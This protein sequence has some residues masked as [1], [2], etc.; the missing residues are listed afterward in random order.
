M[1]GWLLARRG[2]RH[3]WRTHLG[4]LLGV[5]CATTVLVGALSVGDSVRHSLLEQ[6]LWR[7]GQVSSVLATGDRFVQEDLGTRIATAIGTTNDSSI[8]PRCV[9]AIQLAGVAASASGKTRT[10]I[11]D[12]FG[13]DNRFFAMSAGGKQ[14]PAL[15]AGEAILNER[16]AAQLGVTVD[17]EIVVRVEKPSLMP[18]EAAMAT[19]D[20]VSF[21]L[22]VKI[23]DIVDEQEF[24]HFG[25]RASQVPPFNLF[26]SL[27]W[28][29]QELSLPGR[30]NMLLTDASVEAADAALRTKWTIADAE[31]KLT[32]RDLGRTVEL[33][34]TRVFLDSAVVDAVAEIAPESVGVVTY[35]VKSLSTKTASTPYSMVSAI[36]P[37]S[38]HP[39]IA[40][41]RIPA[42]LAATQALVPETTRDDQIICNQWLADDLNLKVGDAIEMAYWVMNSQLQFEERT[43][44]L[45]VHSIVPMTGAAA[46]PSLMPAF[47]GLA[48]ARSCSDWDTGIPVDLQQ[49]SDNDQ[50]YWEENQGTP[51]A[52]V[53]LA[54]GQRLWRN[55]FG[56]LTAVRVSA[57][58]AIQLARQLPELV[59]P[60]ALNLFFQDIRGPAL[61]A[62]VPATDFGALYLGLSFFLIVAALLLAA[63]LFAF[64]VEQRQGEIGTLLAVG[65]EPRTVH[66]LFAR[67]ALVLA[68]IGSAIGAIAGAGYTHA[69]LAALD[70]LW[71]D[72]IGQTTLTAHIVPSSVAFGACCAVLAALLAIAWAMRR[73]FSRPAVELLTSASGVELPRARR[74]WLTTALSLAALAGAAFL[75]GRAQPNRA[76]S[77]FFGGGALLLI[78]ALFACRNL[79]TQLGKKTSVGLRSIAALGM[80]NCGRR[81]GRSLATIALLA[82]GTFLVVAIQANRLTPPVDASQRSAGTGGFTLFGRT[83]LPVLRD[84]DSTAGREAY[85][86][87]DD[88]L[89]GVAIVPLR[90]RSGDDASCLNLATA[91]NPQLVGVEADQLARRACFRFTRFEAAAE[92]VSNPWLLLDRDFGANIVPAI[93]DGGSVAW[94]LHKKLGDSL[95]YRDEAG[96]DFQVRIVG[97]VA[98]SILQGNLIIADHH[99][100]QRFPSASGYRMFLIDAPSERTEQVAAD[101]SRALLDVGLELT[102]TSERLAAF[103]SVQNTYLLIFQLLGGLGLLL[104]TVGLG[105]VVL[106][107]ALE[108]R[109]ELAIAR[110]VGFDHAAV[111][112]LVFHEHGVLL[113][114]GL[115]VGAVAAGL[116]LLPAL[117]AERAMPI[118]PILGFLA[119]IAL[120]GVF[121]VWAASALA[122][123]GRMIDG[124]RGD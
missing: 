93:G 61:A 64:G 49:L 29:Q 104:G 60:K 19:V 117:R 112:R 45:R 87:D 91:Q 78:S 42:A 88:E 65:F 122:T 36:G 74:R 24:G 8:V 97:T 31:L 75:I 40:S 25:L 113:A 79:V 96:N 107:N 20:D 69:V 48:E 106:R 14:L 21:A 2:M 82:S 17:E 4:V 39:P 99:L 66:W 89:A 58:D 83:T 10:G 32:K 102:P 63:M 119:V 57:N 86:L 108:R 1:N 27:A 6:S 55:R 94:A 124:L 33:T 70:T 35:F 47:P 68:T 72:T 51:K 11:V 38:S 90:V 77:A 101:L 73:T 3:Y 123:R 81:P 22:R 9:P 80:R 85:G 118:L 115:A 26:V 7:I 16:L 59:E 43:H 121:W 98:D 44:S 95:T 41:S 92:P 71:R 28:L 76:T 116:A 13:V 23:L 50:K 114:L 52:F 84:L 100:Q 105:I 34:S 67:E 18:R 62:G 120:S 53:T 46:D 15:S 111:R 56:T 110:A 54:T 109:G 30:A 12:V 103:Q 5:A 37:I